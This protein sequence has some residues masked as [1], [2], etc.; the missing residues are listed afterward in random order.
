MKMQKR[1]N[2]HM[3]VSNLLHCYLLAI[4]ELL[5]SMQFESMLFIN[6]SSCNSR[7]YIFEIERLA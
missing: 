5:G 6:P 3:P 2:C 4:D 7:N 1:N